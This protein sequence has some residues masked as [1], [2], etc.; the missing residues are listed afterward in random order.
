MSEV[1]LTPAL[2]LTAFKAMGSAVSRRVMVQPETTPSFS[3][4]TATQDIYFALPSGKTSMIMGQNSY[5]VFDCIMVGGTTTTTASGFCNGSASSAI[6]GLELIVGNTSVELL[7]RYN[8]FA[9]LIEDFQSASRSGTLGEILGACGSSAGIKMPSNFITSQRVAIPIY[10]SIIGTLANQGCPAVDGIRL[11]LTFETLAIAT[12]EQGASG[13]IGT[14]AVA[15]C[16]ISN[17]N[18]VMD[19]LDIDP[20]VHSQLIQESGGV[21]KTHGVGVSNFSTSLGA[22][23][24]SQLSILIPARYSS[25]KNYFTI[26]RNQAVLG[27][28]VALHNSTG[29][30]YNPAIRNY[31]YRIDGRQY[32]SIP[33]I[34]H[35]GTTSQSGEVMAEVL[36]CFD[37]A[38][39]QVFDCVFSKANFLFDNATPV[40]QGAFVIGVDFE[41]EAGS[42]ARVV[43]GKDTNS[44]N[45]FLEAQLNATNPVA[46]QIDTYACYDLILEVNMMTG[47]V[48]VSK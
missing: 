40:N 1:A 45:T 25:V 41:Q 28:N 8:V 46:L 10:S 2:D 13:A 44:N 48:S 16:A 35:N 3:L 22:S 42:G 7:D 24:G 15:S 4:G 39:S 33:V 32:P 11:K 12:Q 26:F 5:I 14:T 43:S 17:L 23:S 19:Y 21:F 30:R 27:A 9:N 20:V 36:K 29:S 31:A 6:R 34:C 38:N 47:E 18:L 37:S